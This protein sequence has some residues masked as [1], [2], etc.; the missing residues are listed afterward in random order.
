M[1]NKNRPLKVY[2][3]SYD[4]CEKNPEFNTLLEKMRKFA[5]DFSKENT[6]SVVKFMDCYH[7]DDLNKM[8][9]QWRQIKHKLPKGDKKLESLYAINDLL[10]TY[11]FRF[12][13]V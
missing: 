12:I 13:K 10:T 11:D 3:P 2:M 1:P 6:E 5:E 7:P 9:F 8:K 4:V